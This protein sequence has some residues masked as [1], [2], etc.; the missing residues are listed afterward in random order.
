MTRDQFDQWVN[1]YGKAWAALDPDAV[2]AMMSPDNITYYES[3][4]E[5][6]AHDIEE[7]R[8]L[9]AVIPSN[10]KDVTFKHEIVVCD[11]NKAFV[12]ARITRTLVPSGEKQDIEA[13]FVFGLDDNGLCNYFRQWRVVR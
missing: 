5:E 8:K 4:F 2:M 11:E 13:A 6:P 1:Q 7:V 3:T 9:W 10:Q 12:H